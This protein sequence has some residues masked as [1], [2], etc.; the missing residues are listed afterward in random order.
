MEHLLTNPDEVL[1]FVQLQL[2]RAVR[3]TRHP[4]HWPVLITGTSGRVVVL[5]SIQ[6]VPGHWCFYTDKRAAKVL[7][8]DEQPF[9]AAVF[10][11]AHRT[12]QLRIR[13][14]HYSLLDEASRLEI[15]Q[16]MP[17][18]SK[19]NY[20]TRTAPGSVLDPGPDQDL[21]EAWASHDPGKEELDRAYENFLPVQLEISDCDFLQLSRQGQLR[22]TWKGLH[23][24]QFQWRVP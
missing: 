8:L 17:L 3:D 23:G 12:C 1:R 19:R 18:H 20:A 21:D 7:Q 24:D 6:L 2:R 4:W 9:S 13:S 14:Q 22:C 11:D 16:K 15:W 5:R 10:Y